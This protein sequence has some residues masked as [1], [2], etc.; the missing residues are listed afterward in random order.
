MK[1][2]QVTTPIK[3]EP[4]MYMDSNAYGNSVAVSHQ[5]AYTY[6]YFQANGTVPAQKQQQEQQEQQQVDTSSA[7]VQRAMRRDMVNA[8]RDKRKSST[9][10]LSVANPPQEKIRRV[11]QPMKTT[12]SPVAC[13]TKKSAREDEASAAPAP[14]EIT[15]PDLQTFLRTANIELDP[16]ADQKIRSMELQLGSLDPDSAEAKNK[17][18]RIRNRMSAQLHR[19][20]KKAYVGQLEDQ[21]C[22]KDRTIRDLN[23]KLKALA[24]ENEALKAEVAESKCKEQSK[25][26]ESSM[27]TS[28]DSSFDSDWTSTCLTDDESVHSF[29]NNLLGNIHSKAQTYLTRHS[30]KIH[31]LHGAKKNIAMMMAVVFSVTFFGNSSLFFNLTSGSSFSSM[32]GANQPDDF[33]AVSITSRILAC[34]EGTNWKSFASSS[35]WKSVDEEQPAPITPSSDS[36]ATISS[37]PN[38]NTTDEDIHEQT[39]FSF[40]YGNNEDFSYPVDDIFCSDFTD[41]LLDPSVETNEDF[42]PD[43]FFVPTLSSS[44]PTLSPQAKERATG[45]M[46]KEVD[47][48]HEALQKLWS[49]KQ[50]VLCSIS[51]GKEVTHQTVVSM[52]EV[53]RCL[54]TGEFAS[55]TLAKSASFDRFHGSPGRSQVMSFLYPVGTTAP[56]GGNS[57]SE[58]NATAEV[59]SS[60]MKPAFVEVSCALNNNNNVKQ[61][62]GSSIM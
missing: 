31:D 14:S 43:D 35:S 46:E 49:E 19:E 61:R 62:L 16:I 55:E 37:S 3:Q 54:K 60:T 29:S 22:Q 28:F 6:K 58:S 45:M 8:K 13:A 36:E 11:R 41:I 42:I 9:A 47:T 20:R 59:R 2:E 7:K 12:P 23:E 34:L 32:F 57:A 30:D 15:K 1:K 27:D 52:D 17:R 53:Q 5:D 50:Q 38:S 39:D 26:E 10:S 44:A 18:R 51:D 48:S 4:P 24:K 40:G 21:I 56:A 33:S 25:P